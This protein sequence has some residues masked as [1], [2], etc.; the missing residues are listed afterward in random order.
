MRILL[1]EFNILIEWQAPNSPE[2]NLLDLGGAWVTIQSVVEWMH[3]QRLM[4]ADVLAGTVFEA[5]DAFDAR[6]LSNISGRWEKVLHLIIKGARSN[7]LVEQ[8]RGLTSTLF[9]PLELPTVAADCDSSDG[10]EEFE[11]N[12]LVAM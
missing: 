9:D 12:Q 5:W 8:E 10:D 4:N 3:R 1:E 2:T 11:R 6:K 7:D